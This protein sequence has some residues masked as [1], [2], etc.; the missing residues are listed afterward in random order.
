[1]AIVWQLKKLKL[2][3]VKQSLHNHKK[4]TTW[5]NA[6]LVQRLKRKSTYKRNHV[7]NDRKNISQQLTLWKLY[8]NWE[9]RTYKP[10]QIYIYLL[11]NQKKRQKSNKKKMDSLALKK[12]VLM[13]VFLLSERVKTHLMNWTHF[14]RRSYCRK[15]RAINLC[16]RYDKA[17]LSP[18]AK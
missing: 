3:R 12:M 2:I 16:F 6:K 4:K 18:R 5:L 11:F 13:A 17:S 7:T 14:Y 1:M 9:Q 8:N 15:Q 10:T